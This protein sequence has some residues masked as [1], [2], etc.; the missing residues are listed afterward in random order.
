MSVHI[1]HNAKALVLCSDVKANIVGMTQQAGMSLSSPA[2][3]A[4]QDGA[5]RG[6]QLLRTVCG[7]VRRLSL[8]AGTRPDQELCQL[9]QGLWR[10]RVRTVSLQQGIVR[11]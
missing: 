11:I 6:R 5:V 8:P 7:A 2:W 10:R 9:H 1:T 3:R 4:L